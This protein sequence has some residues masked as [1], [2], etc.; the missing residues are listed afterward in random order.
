METRKVL[1]LIIFVIICLIYLVS[2]YT[3]LIK[4]EKPRRNISLISY[5]AWFLIVFFGL[6]LD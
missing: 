2:T 1:S 5:I 6:L 4:S 3:P